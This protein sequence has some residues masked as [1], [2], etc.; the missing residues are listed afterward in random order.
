LLFTVLQWTNISFAQQ[1][2]VDTLTKSLKFTEEPSQKVDLLNAIAEKSLEF[3]IDLSL[4][5]AREARAL[6][7]EI[8]YL[9]G[10]AHANKWLGN[11]NTLKGKTAEALHNFMDALLVFQELQDSLQVAHVYKYLANI[12]INN[13]NYKEAMRYYLVAKDIYE[14]LGDT[15]GNSSILN[16]IATIYLSLD[17]ADS[18]LFYLNQSRLSYLEIKDEG[19][20]ATNYTNMGYAYAIKGDF[21]KAI[22][23]YNKCYALAVKINSKETIS[24]ALLNIGDGYMNLAKYVLAEDN[25]RAGLAISEAEGYKY[26]NYIG[27]YTLGEINEKTGNYKE[28]VGWYH[29]AEEIDLE[30]RSSATMSALMD[31]QTMQ[32]E[33]AQRREIDKINT[34]NAEKFA[35][36]R[37]KKILYLSISIFALLLLLG[38]TYYYMKRHNATLKIALQHKEISLQKEQIMAQSGKIKQVNATLRVRNKKLRE[39]NEEKNYMMSVVAHD[40]KSPLNQING[41]ANVIKLDDENLNITQKDCLN[42]IEVASSRLSEMVNKI[43]D[44]RNVENKEKSLQFESIDIEKMA[45]EVLNDFSTMADTKKI[46][47]HKNIANNGASVKA[48]RHYLRQVLDNL[49]SNAIKYSPN[50]KKVN[51]NIMNDGN[52]VL[53][54]VVDEGPGL[55]TEDK[56]KLFTEYAILSAK[57]TGGETS[58]GLGLAIVKNYVE[59]MG[60]KIWCESKF[61]HGAAFKVKLERS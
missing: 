30:L 10:V 27:Y 25:V 7:I 39:L 4:A 16:N 2:V 42:N 50:G 55:T 40:L 22:E 18:A 53:A 38:T 5:K 21:N 49:V 14:R 6:G 15:K 3:D 13:G 48:D 60:G 51:I 61:G 32:L 59:K 26:S 45:G 43:L 34:I 9:L 20:L 52:G 17:N 12:Y 36:E 23:F 47:L 8:E 28:S 1:Q 33:E 37:L 24:T 46:T 58:T 35:S 44:S 54:E 11:G 19:G 57:P 41:L 56:E 29:K 31:V